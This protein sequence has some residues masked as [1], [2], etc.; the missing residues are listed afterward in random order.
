MGSPRYHYNKHTRRYA[1]PIE[2]AQFM[3]LRNEVVTLLQ[4]GPVGQ[5]AIEH[6]FRRQLDLL[7]R[8]L[9]RMYAQEE[10]S[11]TVCNGF[12]RIQ[13][14]PETQVVPVYSLGDEPTKAP[15]KKD[16]AENRKSKY[17][18]PAFF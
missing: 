15:S 14:E 9:R 13:L 11:S 18:K 12:R 16:V 4:Q 3:K 5:V 2:D 8:V 17:P 7:A 1:A 10:I 6:K